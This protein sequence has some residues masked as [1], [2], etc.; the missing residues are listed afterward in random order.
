MIATMKEDWRAL[1]NRQRFEGC[2]GTRDADSQDRG[3][4]FRMS[5]RPRREPVLL[6]IGQ[7]VVQTR[8]RRSWFL[9]LRLEL[10]S[11]TVRGTGKCVLPP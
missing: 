8:G 3:D 1:C 11:R 10:I 4:G 6:S 5:N 9:G 7:T 2:L